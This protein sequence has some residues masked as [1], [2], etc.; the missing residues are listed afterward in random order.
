MRKPIAVV[1]ALI[2]VATFAGCGS[3][4]T[5]SDSSPTRT[6]AVAETTTATQASAVI[7]PGP[8]YDSSV[9]NGRPVDHDGLIAYVTGTDQGRRLVLVNPIHL[10]KSICGLFDAGYDSDEVDN[11]VLDYLNTYYRA[12]S[13]SGVIWT[14]GGINFYTYSLTKYTCPEYESKYRS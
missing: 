4:N 13:G 7:E 9:E 5:P 3:N 1:A 14:I 12:Q 8:A 10:A 11:A 2:A 6:T